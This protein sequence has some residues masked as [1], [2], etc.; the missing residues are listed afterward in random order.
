MD[1]PKDVIDSTRYRAKCMTNTALAKQ[2][3]MVRQTLSHKIKYPG[4]FTGY[5]I[6]DIAQVL[7]WSDQEIAGFI[8]GIRC[9]E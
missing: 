1:T 8:R 2:I 5:E 9:K 6:S 7:N 4:T 3:G